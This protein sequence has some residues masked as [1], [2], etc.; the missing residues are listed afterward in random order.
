MTTVKLVPEVKQAWVK[1]LRSGKYRQ[2]RGQLRGPADYYC[3]LGVLCDLYRKEHRDQLEW[4]PDE[5]DP[6]V[7]RYS[8]RVRNAGVWSLEDWSRLPAV[9]WGW[10]W[11]HD[12]M[13][14]VSAETTLMVMNDGTSTFEEIAQFIE[15]T[16]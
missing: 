16:Y 2:G 5:D 12:G 4:L 10:A 9:V 11:S 1:A 14:P 13:S 8:V 15:D 3:C 6:E 7:G